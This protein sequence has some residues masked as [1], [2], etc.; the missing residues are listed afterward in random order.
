M[1]DYAIDCFGRVDC[2]VN[3]AGSPSPMVSIVDVDMDDYEQVMA[4]NVRGVMLGMK[5]VMPHMLQQ[6]FGAIINISSAAAIRSV[7]PRI[8]TP[9]QKR[10][11]PI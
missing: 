8:P 5:L 4:V 3:S 11:W 7:F 6:G 9:L 10:R 1:I 2:L